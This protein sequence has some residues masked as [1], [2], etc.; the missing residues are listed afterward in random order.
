[1]RGCGCSDGGLV[2]SCDGIGMFA[3]YVRTDLRIGRSMRQTV[4]A[5]MEMQRSTRVLCKNCQHV[6]KSVSIWT[7][8]QVEDLWHLAQKV[9]WPE[10]REE[11]ARQY[12]DLTF[13]CPECGARAGLEEF[14]TGEFGSLD[15]AT[16]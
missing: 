2:I 4:N 10:Y 11:V 13:E 9:E 16:R 1:M 6:T 5:F 3:G 8:E 12:L 15:I 7:R 14:G